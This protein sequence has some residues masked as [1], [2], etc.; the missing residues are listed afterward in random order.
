MPPV[1]NKLV[2]LITR[3]AGWH[4]G[5]MQGVPETGVFIAHD[6]FLHGRDEYEHDENLRM[7]SELCLLN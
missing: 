7:F 4:S 3:D 2:K 5:I 6:L 1:A